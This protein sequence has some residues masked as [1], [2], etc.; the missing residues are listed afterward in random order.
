MQPDCNK[1]IQSKILSFL[2]QRRLPKKNSLLKTKQI[3]ISKCFRKMTIDLE[4]SIEN[5]VLHQ[6]NIPNPTCP[7]CGKNIKFSFYVSDKN[8]R[9][10]DWGGFEHFCSVNCADQ[11][12]KKELSVDSDR[13]KDYE[14]LSFLVKNKDQVSIR[15]FFIGIIEKL[16]TNSF[17]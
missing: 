7:T 13:F 2:V 11:A 10:H 17:S 16:K 5:F 14:H 4:V 3:Y 6:L 12:S 1:S 9:V 8:L 15:N